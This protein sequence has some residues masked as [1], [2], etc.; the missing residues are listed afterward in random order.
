MLARRLFGL[1]VL[2]ICAHPHSLFS[3]KKVVFAAGENQVSENLSFDQ[4]PKGS[5]PTINVPALHIGRLDNAG[6]VHNSRFNSVVVENSLVIP[7]R[8]ETGPWALYKGKKPRLVG[9]I[10][11]HADEFVALKVSN[12][13]RALQR[14]L[15]I[16]TRAP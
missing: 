12:N 14:A 15:Y 9:R 7:T 10:V 6:V 13:P 1:R 16:R 8:I 4:K 3:A 5:E 11:G 2:E